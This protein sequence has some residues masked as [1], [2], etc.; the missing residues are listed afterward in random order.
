VTHA[1]G[2]WPGHAD[3]RGLGP[4]FGCAQVGAPD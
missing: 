1:P 3:V 4:Q 2:S